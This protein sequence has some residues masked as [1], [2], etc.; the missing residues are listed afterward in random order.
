MFKKFLIAATVAVGVCG[1]S[2]PA[3]ASTDPSVRV[4]GVSVEAHK[5]K[6]KHGKLID[7][8]QVK[9]DHVDASDVEVKV[10]NCRGNKVVGWTG[11]STPTTLKGDIL[12]QR[13][14]TPRGIGYVS[15]KVTYPNGSVGEKIHHFKNVK[16]GVRNAG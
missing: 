3:Q 9:V 5:V 12:T 14:A 8:V 16:C 7:R 4:G 13:I 2:M 11:W 10:Y 1:A 6:F 15:I